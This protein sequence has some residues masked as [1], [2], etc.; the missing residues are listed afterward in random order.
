MIRSFD[1][2]ATRDTEEGKLDYEG[3]FTPRVLEAYAR[4]MNFN[5]TMRDGSIRASD[6]WQKG[7]PSDAYMK[8]GWRHFM[9]WWC[10]H[11]DYPK[12]KHQHIVFVLCAILFNVM[13]YLDNLLKENPEAIDEA[14]RVAQLHRE[15]ELRSKS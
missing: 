7:I 14:L 12:G 13:G 10:F 2:G 4:Y 6:N 11:R 1:T 15:Q 9:E 5:R 3:F 8:S